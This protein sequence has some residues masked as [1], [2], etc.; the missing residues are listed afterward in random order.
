MGFSIHCSRYGDGLYRAL[1]FF[2]WK[3]ALRFYCINPFF[4]LF[5]SLKKLKK[6][7]S[8]NNI[9]SYLTLLG[10]FLCGGFALQQYSLLYTDVANS[11]IF[12][13][14]Y[15]LIVPA[16]SYFLF[17]KKKSIGLFG[18]RSLFV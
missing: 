1:F 15:V 9:L 14:F 10:F 4:F 13:I 18:P 17:S 7:F 16:I 6:N 3:N 8:Y 12:T 2:C 11:A 5:L